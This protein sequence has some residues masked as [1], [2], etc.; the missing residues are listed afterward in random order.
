MGYNSLP[1]F[2]QVLELEGECGR[3]ER[4]DLNFS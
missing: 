1:D 3:G 2:V 4:N